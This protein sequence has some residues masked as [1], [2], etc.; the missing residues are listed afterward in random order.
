MR[1]KDMCVAS[2][3]Q[4]TEH[5]TKSS[6]HL[7]EKLSIFG[8]IFHILR[9]TSCDLLLEALY[10]LVDVAGCDEIAGNVQRL[11][12]DVEVRCGQRNEQ[13]HDQHLQ[14]ATVRVF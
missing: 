14:R 4:D 9:L 5:R 10:D 6:P 11:L 7:D 3:I 12:A 8:P 1:D 13:V 2:A